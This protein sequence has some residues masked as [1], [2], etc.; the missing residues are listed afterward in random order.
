MFE[1]ILLKNKKLKKLPWLIQLGLAHLITYKKKKELS[2]I[3]SSIETY[4]TFIGYPRSGHSLIAA[5]L[6]AHPHIVMAHEFRAIKYIAYGLERNALYYL[7]LQNTVLRGHSWKR[8][9]GYTF[10]VLGQW[11]GAF[12][13]KIHV[14]GDKHG[15]FNTSYLA[16][17]PELLEKLGNVVQVP[18]LYIH[19]IRNP[20]DNIT[21]MFLR[22]KSQR[23][24]GL[25]Q[26]INNYFRLCESVAY[27]K[28]NIKKGY[29]YDLHHEDFIK[30]PKDKLQELCLWLRVE[31]SPSYLDACTEIVFKSP[32]KSRHKIQWDESLKQ[33]VINKINGF[34]FLQRYTFE[35]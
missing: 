5:L 25:E 31:P 16:N 28:K 27:L 13:K 32:Q 30:S 33:K 20:F 1:K 19:V 11:Q 34:S 9:S 3:F 14:I 4:C 23:S 22:H 29:I 18:V 17:Q 7:L 12:D 24:V 8:G 21:T 15:P 2:S 35:N 10:D 6:D 26:I